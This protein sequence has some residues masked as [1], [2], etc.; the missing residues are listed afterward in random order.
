MV[1]NDSPWKID[2]VGATR[3]IMHTAAKVMLSLGLVFCVIGGV[4]WYGGSEAI[5][6]D[7]ENDAS[8]QGTS[9]TWDY[10]DDDYYTVYAK[11]GTACDGFEATMT[12]A[13][14]STG[15]GWVENIELLECS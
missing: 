7:I 8:Y 10:D 5:E 6:T 13:N 12:D 2:K 1:Q 11:K 15:S 14:G 3:A 4:M 9:G